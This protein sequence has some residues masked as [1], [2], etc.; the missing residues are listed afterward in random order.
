MQPAAAKEEAA[1]QRLCRLTPAARS[2]SLRMA[3]A[4]ASATTAAGTATPPPPAG[5]ERLQRIPPPTA[6][7]A[8]ATAAAT[9]TA[10][11]TAVSAAAAAEAA[12]SGVLANV[13]D[14]YC[15]GGRPRIRCMAA[16]A[17]QRRPHRPRQSRPQ[18]LLAAE[19]WDYRQR[20]PGC[21]SARGD[22]RAAG[23]QLNRTI[24]KLQPGAKRSAGGSFKFGSVRRRCSVRP[25]PLQ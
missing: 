11:A 5:E 14:C 9:A 16:A 7:P 6:A 18:P 2:R 3:A 17:V 10:T 21:R 22:L 23:G 20:R 1:S 13:S 19:L 25:A 8:A 12:A 15:R 4:A 24:V